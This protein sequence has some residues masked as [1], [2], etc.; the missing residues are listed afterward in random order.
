MRQ[1]ALILIA[2]DNE[3]NRDIL[4]RRLEAHGYKSHHGKRWG[5]GARRGTQHAAGSDPP[6]YHDAENWTDLRF[7]DSSRLTRAYH[8]S[9]LSWLQP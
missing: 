2:D 4:A 9:Q 5:A 7:A 6:R 3:A 8:L 1:P